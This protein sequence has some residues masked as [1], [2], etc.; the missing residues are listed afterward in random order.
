MIDR[1]DHRQAHAQAASPASTRMRRAKYHTASASTARKPSAPAKRACAESDIGGQPQARDVRQADRGHAER[2]ARALHGRQDA[3]RDAG[4]LWRRARQRER[5][6]RRHDQADAGALRSAT[7]PAS[8]RCPAPAMPPAACATW[9][10]I[11]TSAPI[12]TSGRLSVR[13][14]AAPPIDAAKNAAPSTANTKPE[15]QRLTRRAWTAG[16][17]RA[18]SRTTRCRRKTPAPC[19]RR[20][21]TAAPTPARAGSSP[22]AWPCC[23]SAGSRMKA[24]NRHGRRDQQADVPRARQGLA[25]IGE[26]DD[27]AGERGRRQHHAPDVDATTLRG[28]AASRSSSCVASTIATSAIGALM[29]KQLRQPVPAKFEL[30]Q[31]AAEH[32]AHHAGQAHRHRIGCERA[33][34]LGAGEVRARAAPAPAGAAMH[35]TRLARSAST[36]ASGPR[37]RGRRRPRW[38]RTAPCPPGTS[39]DG[40]TGRRACRRRSARPRWR[41]RSRRRSTAAVLEWLRSR[42]RSTASATSTMKKSSTTMNA[43]ARITSRRALSSSVMR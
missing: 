40:R 35:P 17:G 41:C 19:R 32:L 10:P 22:T 36:P 2:I 27:Q 3:R 14:M 13:P 34:A 7:A 21:G 28:S 31:R 25:A 5:H 26:R 33:R 18:R 43:P 8:P 30:D 12:S 24:T 39:G 6:Q 38:R 9:P 23:A 29:K 42:W 1:V 15:P 16:A 20:D 37:W 4:V 11:N